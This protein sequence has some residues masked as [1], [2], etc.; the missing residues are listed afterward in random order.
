MRKP[1]THT[2]PRGQGF[3]LIELLVVIGIIAILLG[4]TF[5]VVNKLRERA[6]EVQCSNNMRQWMSAMMQYVDENKALFPGDG[7][8]QQ[9]TWQWYEVL[10]PIIGLDPFSVQSASTPPK[11]PAPGLGKSTFICPSYRSDKAFLPGN[12][13]YA[14]SYGMNYW[15]NADGKPP[16]YTKRMRLSQLKRADLFVVFAETGDYTKKNVALYPVSKATTSAPAFRHGKKT[17]CGFAD[18]HISPATEAMAKNLMWNP[19]YEPGQEP[20]PKD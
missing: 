19:N 9:E 11:V 17:L 8:G 7:T 12:S 4:L 3:T 6:K 10:P 1:H 5:P 15:V 18:G 13:E 2:P 16:E 14:Y 20:V